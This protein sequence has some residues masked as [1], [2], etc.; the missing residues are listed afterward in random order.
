MEGITMDLFL[1]EHGRK[2][3]V[4]KGDGNCFFRAITKGLFDTEEEHYTIRSCITRF[5]LMNSP[6]FKVYMIHGTDISAHVCKMV[7]PGTWATHLEVIAVA[8]YFNM[9][10]FLC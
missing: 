1:H 9:P 10:V 3:C 4:V 7:E 2:R 5:M 6:T 8:T